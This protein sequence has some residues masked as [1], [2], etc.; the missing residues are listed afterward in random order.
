MEKKALNKLEE[1]ISK[2]EVSKYIFGENEYAFVNKL[3]ETPTDLDTIF[4]Q[5]FN[6][7]IISEEK[8]EELSGFI[9]K[10][11]VELTASQLGLWWCI[12]FIHDFFFGYK[13]GALKF[14]FDIETVIESINQSIPKY[15][16]ELKTDK[17]FLGYRFENGLWED[18]ENMVKR[19][20]TK[21]GDLKIIL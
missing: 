10:S 19:I 5:G 15:K 4:L 16:E 7:F 18:S 13:E 12:F 14:S 3:L 2:M 20:N 17:R 21:I 6:K 1:S 9:T 8:K 11:L